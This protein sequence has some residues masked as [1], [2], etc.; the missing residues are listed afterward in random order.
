MPRIVIF[1]GVFVVPGLYA[2]ASQDAEL[3]KA[4]IGGD[5]ILT[6]ALIEQGADVNCSDLEGNTPLH[7][8]VTMQNSNIL[9]YF[10]AWGARPKGI[11][12]NL[13]LSYIHIILELLAANAAVNQSN[14]Q[15]R[16]AL[17]YAVYQGHVD[18]VEILLDHGADVQVLDV[19][20]QTPLHIAASH[21]DVP[22]IRFLLDHGGFTHEF[23][24]LGRT[25]L[26]LAVST[27]SLPIVKLLLIEGAVV[28]K[29]NRAGKTPLKRALEKGYSEIATCLLLHGARVPDLATL[30]EGERDILQ[31]VLGPLVID[32]LSSACVRGNTD[33]VRELLQAPSCRVRGLEHQLRALKRFGKWLIDYI[34]QPRITTPLHWAVAQ[35]YREI[36]QQ[37]LADGQRV[38]AKNQYGNTPLHFA[39][40]H[41]NLPLAHMLIMDKA[42]DTITNDHGLTPWQLAC[43]SGYSELPTRIAMPIIDQVLHNEHLLVQYHAN[44]DP[45]SGMPRINALPEELIENIKK[46][47]PRKHGMY[48]VP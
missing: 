19:G 33:R 10:E 39:A 37:L 34:V 28:S 3:L 13:R 17:H 14:D 25:C 31:A 8:A 32:E 42:R 2:M 5:F 41:N 38:D 9:K 29:S 35:D 48:H 4:A 12:D 22:M 27:G 7:Y 43:K 23:N 21:G 45:N 1:L 40:A 11:P 44:T 47:L 26:D 20:R 24:V 15:K 46:F 16:T 6:K 36:V 30:A 18:V